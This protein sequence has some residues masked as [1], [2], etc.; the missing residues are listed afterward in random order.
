MVS[1]IKGKADRLKMNLQLPAEGESRKP[2]SVQF[3]SNSNEYRA[4]LLVLDSTIMRF[5][6]NPLFRTPNTLEVDLAAK[7]RRDLEAVI[8]LTV[9]L[10][11]TALRLSKASPSH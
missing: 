8:A 5:V 10:K 2:N 6:N 4:A 11:K 7:A 9:D 1:R 3:I